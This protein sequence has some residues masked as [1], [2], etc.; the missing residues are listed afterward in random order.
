MPAARPN[1][2]FNLPDSEGVMPFSPSLIQPG[3]RRF[4]LCQKVAQKI[5]NILPGSAGAS[6]NSRTKA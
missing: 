3:H 6:S 2:R 4:D 5:K 1:E